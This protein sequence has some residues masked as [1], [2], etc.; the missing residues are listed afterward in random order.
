M[1]CCVENVKIPAALTA[2]PVCQFCTAAAAV[3]TA[4]AEVA[5]WCPVKDSISPLTRVAVPAPPVWIAV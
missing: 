3:L 5:R 1:R 4:M 2:T